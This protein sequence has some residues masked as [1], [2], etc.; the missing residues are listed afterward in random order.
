M[1]TRI[2]KPAETDPEDGEILGTNTWEVQ[3]RRMHGSAPQWDGRKAQGNLR[4][5]AEKPKGAPKPGRR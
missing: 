5:M 3:S 1:F 4:R 2:I